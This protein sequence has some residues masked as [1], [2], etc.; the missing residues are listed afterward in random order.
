MKRFALLLLVAFTALSGYAQTTLTL[1]DAVLNGRKY[2]PQGLVMPQWVP[3]TDAYS[4][5][6]D[7]YQSL[8]VVD[9]KSGEET[10]RITA[11]E[12]NE[13]LEGTEVSI[14]GTWMLNWLD[15]NTLVFHRRRERS[16]PTLSQTKRPLRPSI[17]WLP[18]VAIFTSVPN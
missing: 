13:T 9:A 4:H 8:V 5:V 2:Y 3:G 17:P 16:T 15:E 12:I 10:G 18:G 1:E 6:T 14:R 11:G 7:G